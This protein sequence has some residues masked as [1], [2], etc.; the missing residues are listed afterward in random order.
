MSNQIVEQ[1]QA[2]PPLLIDWGSNN[3]SNTSGGFLCH[4][5]IDI[6]GCLGE[7]QHG[8]YKPSKCAWP[9]TT[10]LCEAIED[11][12]Q[13]TA[14]KLQIVTQPVQ[15]LLRRGANVDCARQDG[16]SPLTLAVWHAGNVGCK[17]DVTLVDPT[18]PP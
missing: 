6:P 17:L 14:D 13:H 1:L 7:V 10:P 3:T 12:Y 11:A 15:D 2:N 9:N 5:H 16:E 4:Y 8:A 18:I